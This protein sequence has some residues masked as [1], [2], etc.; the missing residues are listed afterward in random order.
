MGWVVLS[1]N[2]QGAYTL[3]PNAV[4]PHIR[5]TLWAE[6]PDSLWTEQPVFSPGT[7]KSLSLLCLSQ[8]SQHLGAQEGLRGLGLG[9]TGLGL[10]SNPDTVLFSVTPAAPTWPEPALHP[11]QKEP[12]GLHPSQCVDSA[13]L[14]RQTDSLWRHD[15]L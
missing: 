13:P 6:N 9:G 2:G 8:S 11:G 1:P 14:G 4:P 12:P 10:P 5:G 15:C 7:W 3:P